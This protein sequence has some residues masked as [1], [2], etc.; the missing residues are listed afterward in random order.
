MIPPINTQR[1]SLSISHQNHGR[2]LTTA[3]VEIELASVRIAEAS[4]ASLGSSPLVVVF[5][6]IRR[7]LATLSVADRPKRLAHFVGVR[8]QPARARVSGPGSEAYVRTWGAE[9]PRAPLLPLVTGVGGRA[10]KPRQRGAGRG[11][12]VAAWAS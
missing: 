5:R 4:F 6:C 9:W 1:I 2:K 7:H 3:H 11:D 8:S 12:H 10:D